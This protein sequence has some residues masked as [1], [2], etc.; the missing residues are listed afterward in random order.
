MSHSSLIRT[1]YRQGFSDQN[2]RSRFFRRSRFSGFQGT[3]LSKFKFEFGPMTLIVA[4]IIAAVVIS[5]IYLAHFNKVATKGY[6]LRRL[7]ADRQ[8]LLG[9]HDLKNMRLADV[10]SMVNILNSQKVSGMRRVND[11]IFIRGNTALA[12][13]NP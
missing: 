13:L 2:R 4:L 10:K 6:D 3:T 12:S 8:H 7:E 1:P 5:L 11:L 9:E